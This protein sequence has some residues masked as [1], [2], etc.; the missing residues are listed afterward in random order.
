MSLARSEAVRTSDFEVDLLGMGG[1][2]M[3]L[4]LDLKFS[5]VSKM[6]VNFVQA[7]IPQR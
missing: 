4:D 3:R 2:R 1:G 7:V 5:A 6:A